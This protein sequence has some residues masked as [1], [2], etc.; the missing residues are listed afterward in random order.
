MNQPGTQ[1]VIS[2]RKSPS[3]LFQV[4]CIEMIQRVDTESLSAPQ[5]TVPAFFELVLHA[6]QQRVAGQSA[7]MPGS[8][9]RQK[10]AAVGEVVTKDVTNLLQDI[11]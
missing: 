5:L 11:V 3:A 4:D 1:S 9:C 7:L 10:W 8:L 2:E 6:P